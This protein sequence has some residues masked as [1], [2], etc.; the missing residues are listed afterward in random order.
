MNRRL[1]R[2]EQALLEQLVAERER[3]RRTKSDSRLQLP[4]YET[5]IPATEIPN[6]SVE[7]PPSVFVIDL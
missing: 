4:L 2:Y 1:S 3:R 6:P 5:V 7:R